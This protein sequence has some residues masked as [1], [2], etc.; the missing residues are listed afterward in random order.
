MV[1]LDIVTQVVKIL[2]DKSCMCV[3]NQKSIIL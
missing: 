3:S 2:S 1:Y